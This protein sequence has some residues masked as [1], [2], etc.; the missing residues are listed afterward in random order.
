VSGLESGSFSPFF[1]N[2]PLPKNLEEVATSEDTRRRIRPPK[3]DEDT[4]AYL[5]G[6]IQ[7]IENELNHTSNAAYTYNFV[8]HIWDRRIF[9]SASGGAHRFATAHYIACK[10]QLPLLLKG[11]LIIRGFDKDKV[12]ALLNQC[13]ALAIKDEHK[14]IWLEIYNDLENISGGDRSVV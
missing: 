13:Y 14:K 12:N 6:L 10:N 2:A 3:P 11:N 7:S 4:S 1:S 9:W 5:D 8:T